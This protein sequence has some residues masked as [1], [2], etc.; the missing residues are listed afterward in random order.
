MIPKII[1]YCWIGGAEMPELEQ[2]C[3]ASWHQH[4]PDWEYRRW[5]ASNFDIAEAPLYGRW[6]SSAGC[7]WMWILWHIG[8]LMS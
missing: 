1:H 4:M 7:T 8:R 6:R 5:D 3:L 2:R